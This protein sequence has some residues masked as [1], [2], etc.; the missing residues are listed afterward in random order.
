MGFVTHFIFEDNGA[1]EKKE[2]KYSLPKPSNMRKFPY[3][4]LQTLFTKVPVVSTRDGFQK[5]FKNEDL[6]QTEVQNFSPINRTPTLFI[7]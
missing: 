4:L 5:F 6:R 2:N 7:R 3:L 1:R